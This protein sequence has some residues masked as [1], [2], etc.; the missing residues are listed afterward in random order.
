MY[1]SGHLDA[2]KCIPWVPQHVRGGAPPRPRTISGDVGE[3]KFHRADSMQWAMRTPVVFD[4]D[5]PATLVTETPRAGSAHADKHG[6]CYLRGT[7]AGLRLT[8]G[9]A[10]STPFALLVLRSARSLPSFPDLHTTPPLAIT[11]DRRVSHYSSVS[12]ALVRPQQTRV[13]TATLGTPP[14]TPA[15]SPLAFTTHH[16]IAHYNQRKVQHGAARV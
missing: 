7:C 12:M 16:P 8:V 10:S 9:Q 1:D 5:A 6:G 4:T 13:A 15:L 2:W 14:P 11:R 3:I